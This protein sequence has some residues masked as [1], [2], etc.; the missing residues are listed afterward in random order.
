[1]SD[2]SP[3]TSFSRR[4]TA[5]LVSG[6]T[7]AVIAYLVSVLAFFVAGQ[8]ATSVLAGLHSFFV[9]TALFGFLFSVVLALVGGYG[10][11][12]TALASGVVAGALG[13]LVGSS[14]TAVAGGHPF[15]GEVAQYSVTTLVG[16]NLIFVIALVVA[17]MTVGATVWSRLL[18]GRSGISRRIALVRPPAASL[19]DGELTHLERVPVDLDLA[20]SQWDAYVGALADNGWDIR[21]V[22]LADELADSVFIEDAVVMFGKTAVLTSPGAESRRGETEAVEKAV[23]R[24]GQR[25]ER[26]EL[27]GTLDGGDVLKVGK[28]VY[29]GRGGRTNAEGIR[30]LRVIVARLGYKVVAV[31]VSM[32]LHLKSSVTALPDGTIIGFPPIVDNVAIFDRFLAVPEIGGLA[33][34]VVSEDTV[35]MA[36]SAPKSAA[37]IAD[38]GYKVITVDISEFEKLEG[39][40]TCLSVRVR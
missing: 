11:W 35:I 37:L 4:I 20:N 15:D 34:M 32:A 8:G 7:V 2:K 17:T 3:T 39:C 5:A 29:V 26:I 33:V 31:P 30:Q 28:T 36:A 9:W 19:A 22:P 27:P 25:I 16:P 40:V 13:A 21:E 10:R 18:G 38:L 6:L 23:R 12:Y 1:M 14:L 24:L